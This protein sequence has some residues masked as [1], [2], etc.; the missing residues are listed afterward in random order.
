[1]SSVELKHVSRQLC[2]V[3]AEVVVAPTAVHIPLVQ[4]KLRKDFAVAAQNCW[5]KG[6]GAYTGE[7]RSVGCCILP[8]RHFLCTARMVPVRHF[9]EFLTVLCPV[10]RSLW[11]WTSLG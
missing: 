2:V 5:V 10:R 11:T 7:L 8:A 9:I 6:S 3:S 4:A 1:M